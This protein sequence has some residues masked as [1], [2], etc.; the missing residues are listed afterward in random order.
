MGKITFDLGNEELN[1]A[2]KNKLL[3][4]EDDFINR[5]SKQQ[6]IDIPITEED[7]RMFE[8]LVKYGDEFTWVF[9]TQEGIS[10]RVN[11]VVNEEDD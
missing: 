2:A 8:E 4:Q 1:N 5:G 7:I 3:N 10:I 11:F 6:A 9:A